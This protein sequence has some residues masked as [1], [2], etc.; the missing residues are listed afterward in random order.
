MIEPWRIQDL[1]NRV[2][3]L[4]LFESYGCLPKKQG[5]EFVVK[6]PFHPDDT[7]SLFVNPVKKVWHCFGCRASGDALSLVMQIEKISFPQSFEKLSAL[8]GESAPTEA[9]I[10]RR[11]TDYY[12]RRF[13]ETAR[14]YLKGR[15]IQS[16]ELIS[17]HRIGY[18]DGTLLAHLPKEPGIVEALKKSGILLENGRE[19]FLN[20]VVFPLCDATG[21]P[22]SVYGRHTR[23]KKGGHFYLPGPKRGIFGGDGQPQWQPH[24]GQPQGIA[25]TVIAESVMDALAF[26]EHGGFSNVLALYGVNGFTDDHRRWLDCLRPAH[27]VLAFDGDEPGSRAARELKMVLEKSL[28]LPSVT[29]LMFPDGMDANDYFL[30]NMGR[31][32]TC[33]Y[34]GFG[35]FAK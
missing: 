22:V 28:Y 13:G 24:D 25:P 12:H 19:R 17:R 27:I 2:D 18:C 9:D 4:Q 32:E 1:K 34:V 30:K 15:G 29:V 33:P 5:K 20:C 8:I 7:P 21:Q 35:W 6:C 16:E 11:I 14:A 3:L 10:L 31:H 23:M 26:M